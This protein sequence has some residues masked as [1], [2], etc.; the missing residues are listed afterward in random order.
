MI[1]FNSQQLYSDG[2]MAGDLNLRLLATQK[3]MDSGLDLER[4]VLTKGLLC[5]EAGSV[6]G[7]EL[8]GAV[9]NM[10]DEARIT[11]L[12]TRHQ[13]VNFFHTLIDVL[14]FTD[15]CKQ[16]HLHLDYNLKRDVFMDLKNGKYARIFPTK[17]TPDAIAEIKP[18]RAV[19]NQ[20]VLI[21]RVRGTATLIDQA[22]QLM[23]ESLAPLIRSDASQPTWTP[24]QAQTFD[25]AG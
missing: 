11:G 8:E 23:A 3:I 1:M 10:W 25:D 13:M 4:F 7:I 22:L 2:R 12:D 24:D 9:K 20:R 17:I 19:N 6:Y 15:R 14:T 5:S 16:D 21:E 18:T